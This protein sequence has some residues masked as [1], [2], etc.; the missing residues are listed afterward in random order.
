M[1]EASENEDYKNDFYKFLTSL[2][3]CILLLFLATVHS[4]IPKQCS[5]LWFV[6]LYWSVG[7]CYSVVAQIVLVLRLNMISLGESSSASLQVGDP[8]HQRHPVE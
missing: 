3:L 8:E 7:P 4:Y 5:L 6:K 2:F 1:V